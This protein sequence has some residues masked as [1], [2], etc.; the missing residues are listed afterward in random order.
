M[1]PSILIVDDEEGIRQSLTS[2]LRDEGFLADAVESGEACL[3]S[4]TRK[5]WDVLL[6]DIWL[7]GM[8]GLQVLDPAKSL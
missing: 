2:V 3:E 7:P 8:D 5:Q 6:L 4:L 1:R